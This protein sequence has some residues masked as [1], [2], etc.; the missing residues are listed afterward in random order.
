MT[1]NANFFFKCSGYT[2][3]FRIQY[4]IKILK[5]FLGYT[6]YIN[7]IY[8]Y[9]YT[10]Q[11]AKILLLPPK[12]EIIMVPSNHS[13]SNIAIALTTIAVAIA[14]RAITIWEAIQKSSHEQIYKNPYKNLSIEI[15]SDNFCYRKVGRAI[16]KWR[17]IEKNPILR[18]Q[19]WINYHFQRVTKIISHFDD[20]NNIFV[21]CI[22][23]I[24]YIS[25]ITPH[26]KLSF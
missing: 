11:S 15:K 1:Q 16:T 4:V 17:A 19:Y 7:I 3:S 18:Q 12:Y 9:I 8:V 6:V 2:T 5:C 25:T 13:N 10:L 20:S 22:V 24:Y 23:H 21:D 26:I 14:G